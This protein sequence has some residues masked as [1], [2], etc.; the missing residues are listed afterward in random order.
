[1][2]NLTAC[3]LGQGRAREFGAQAVSS[4]G[5]SRPGWLLWHGSFLEHACEREGGDDR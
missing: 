5:T 1:M 4:G 2:E 3:Y